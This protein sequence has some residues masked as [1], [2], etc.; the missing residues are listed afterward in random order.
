M[1]KRSSA[2]GSRLRIRGVPPR[3]AGLWLIAATVIGFSLAFTFML[4][5]SSSCRAYTSS[6]GVYT[7]TSPSLFNKLVVLGSKKTL[8]A[9]MF[10]SETCPECRHMYPLWSSLETSSKLPMKL[11]DVLLER[12]TMV[13]FSKYRVYDLPTFMVFYGGKP[14]A[15]HVGGFSSVEGLREWLISV[16]DAVAFKVY[17]G[18]RGVVYRGW[19]IYGKYCS[20]CHGVLSSTSR[21]GVEAWA[22]ES[23]LGSIVASVYPF[24]KRYGGFVGLV[25]KVYSMGLK[26]NIS[27]LDVIAVAYLLD[28][29]SGIARGVR[30]PQVPNTTISLSLGVGGAGVAS[31]TS[32][33]ASA[34]GLSVLIISIL[35]CAAA[36]VVAAFS[37]CVL[38]LLVSYASSLS[39]EGVTYGNAILCSLAATGGVI[40][41][42]LCFLALGG[43]VQAVQWVLL[44]VVGGVIAA[45]GAAS[46][47][48]VPSFI[49]GFRLRGRGFVG[50]CSVYGLLA[51]QCNLPIVIGALLLVA[52]GGLVAGAAGAISFALGVGL[53]L[54]V[55]VYA[56]SKARSIVEKLTKRSRLLEVVGGL[57]MIAA[58]AALVA[59]GVG[60]F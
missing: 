43:V 9:V 31:P 28:Y 2:R 27:S 59:H 57:V 53:P 29:L 12:S 18:V 40:A 41:V 49:G 46:L 10:R 21:A 25:S 6:V 36:G 15:R 42:S 60:L 54:G 45:A 30:P 33:P 48:G 56:S 47:L 50:F 20:S 51:V 22:R 23:K 38:P 17:G 32:L 35:A 16:A 58:G 26:Y 11:Y 4:L 8:V 13:L 19:R 34:G 52:A 39:R 7:I 5:E 37:P 24:D 44:P 14:V 1:P 55:L 3:R